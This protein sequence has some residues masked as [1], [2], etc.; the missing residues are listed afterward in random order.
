MSGTHPALRVIELASTRL[1]Q[2][3]ASLDTDQALGIRLELR[4]AAWGADSDYLSAAQI[5]RLAR[6]LPEQVTVD[7]AAVAHDTVFSSS[8]G[9]ILLNLLLLAA[10]SLPAGGRITLAGDPDDLFIRISGPGAAWPAGIA[11]CLANEVEARSALTERHSLQMAVTA[12][13]AHAVGIRLSLL[14][15]PAARTEPAIL[16]LG[17]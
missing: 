9:R 11:L 13:L 10:D 7:A 5:Q 17:G 2:D 6:G 3:I 4:R 14:I 16:R 12:L 8:T 15:P 1:C